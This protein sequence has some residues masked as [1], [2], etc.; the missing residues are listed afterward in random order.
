MRF[1]LVDRIHE[2]T[3]NEKISGVKNISMSED[4]LEFHFPRFPVMPGV[5]MLEALTQLAGWLEA[6]SSDFE[7]WLVLD[8][9]KQSKFYGFALPG[10]QVQIE[11]EAQPCDEE[12]YKV[13][14]GVGKVEKRRCIVAEIVTRVVPMLDIES[15]EEQRQ[16]FHVL[17]RDLSRLSA[18]SKRKR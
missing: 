8:R 18:N 5:M 17:T 11:I 4:F 10:D 9:V 14:R 15:P 7:N 2:W 6:A 13:F 12:G 16:L 3:P 1:F